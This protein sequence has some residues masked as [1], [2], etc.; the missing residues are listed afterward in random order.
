MNNWKKSE[1]VCSRIGPSGLRRGCG[2][3]RPA[4]G[5][6]VRF[7]VPAGHAQTPNISDV[8]FVRPKGAP[9]QWVKKGESRKSG[10]H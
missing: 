5:L 9:T 10:H 8:P 1:P 6:S 3:R 7:A 4:W 2:G